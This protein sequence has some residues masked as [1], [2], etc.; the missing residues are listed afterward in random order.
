MVSPS[1]NR[2][3]IFVL[4]VE[5]PKKS[6]VKNKESEFDLPYK[7]KLEDDT[8]ESRGQRIEEKTEEGDS[9]KTGGTDLQTALT[10]VENS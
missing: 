9:K 8:K 1:L 2:A 4:S 7:Y 10:P 3:T 5:L 6:L